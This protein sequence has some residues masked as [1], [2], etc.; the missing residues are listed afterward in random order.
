[1]RAC[2]SVHVCAHVYK[3]KNDIQREHNPSAL[4]PLTFTIKK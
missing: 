2:V 4:S 1:M 3:G